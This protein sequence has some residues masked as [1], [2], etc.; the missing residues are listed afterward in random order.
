MKKL[1]KTVRDY[2][3][4]NRAFHNRAAV[5]LTCVFALMVANEYSEQARRADNLPDITLVQDV[6]LDELLPAHVKAEGRV[7]RLDDLREWHWHEPTRMAELYQRQVW[8]VQR[9]CSYGQA[10][11]CQPERR[12]VV[13]G[14]YDVYEPSTVY[15][16][17][18]YTMHE[19]F[20]TAM[21]GDDRLRDLSQR[22]GDVL[23]DERKEMLFMVAEHFYN[24]FK[25]D[26]VDLWGMDLKVL[27]IAGGAMA[28][29]NEY[30]AIVFKRAVIG[31]DDNVLAHG[32]FDSLV[33]TMSHEL[34]HVAQSYLGSM[35]SDPSKVTYLHK[36][37]IR[38]DI[39][40]L[41]MIR[42]SL[43][44]NGSS[45]VDGVMKINEAYSRRPIEQDARSIEFVGV[46]LKNEFAQ[47]DGVAQ[48]FEFVSSLNF[49]PQVWTAS[50]H[51]TRPV[52]ALPAA[53]KAQSTC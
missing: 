36:N 17:W 2:N 5:G 9:D 45:C 13:Q 53:P 32:S 15:S 1:L 51:D 52:E 24:V 12:A 33:L 29:Q 48:E 27:P 20:L 39:Y 14:L 44:L 43:W 10:Y 46:S 16:A 21:K 49:T 11:Y 31:M 42:R 18:R 7:T 3:R 25:A 19:R 41:H 23:P 37:G 28:W 35:L 47:R 50:V 8:H 4:K 38:D 34:W 22:W 40:M 6:L 26:G 30:D